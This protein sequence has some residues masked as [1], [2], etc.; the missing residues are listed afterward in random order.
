MQSRT[1]ARRLRCRAPRSAPRL[2][3]VCF[4][5]ANVDDIEVTAIAGAVD[6]EVTFEQTDRWSEYVSGPFIRHVVLGGLD[7]LQE[8]R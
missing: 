7:S 8:S 1:A 6:S 4:P 5:H 2:R 3:L